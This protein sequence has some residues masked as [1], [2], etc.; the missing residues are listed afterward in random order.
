[1]L[2]FFYAP[3][4]KRN[5]WQTFKG[6]L[7]Q[8]FNGFGIKAIV[9][10]AT[11]LQLQPNWWI[12]LQSSKVQLKKYKLNHSRFEK[13]SAFW[14]CCKTGI[15]TNYKITDYNPDVDFIAANLLYLRLWYC[16]LTVMF[17]PRLSCDFFSLYC[18]YL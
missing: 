16:E 6:R 13:I 3:Y 17:V 4:F 9:T 12:M 15:V 10:D 8:P 2:V 5:A 1:M 7:K 14:Q 11:C 18:S